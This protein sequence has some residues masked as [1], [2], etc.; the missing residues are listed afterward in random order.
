[1]LTLT[2]EVRSVLDQLDATFRFVHIGPTF[3]PSKHDET[4]VVMTVPGHIKCE[5]F[6]NTVGEAYFSATGSSESDALEKAVRGAIDAP[7]PL[8]KSQRLSM[9]AAE[10]EAMKSE[11]ESLKNRIAEL[12]AAIA[13]KKK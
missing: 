12:E 2:E 7:K 4:K 6:D 8:T 13:G 3:G 1:M 11:N 9:K 10:G 5:I